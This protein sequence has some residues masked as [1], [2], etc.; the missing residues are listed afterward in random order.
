MNTY[1]C[2]EN[3]SFDDYCHRISTDIKLSA[4][5]TW[6]EVAKIINLNC[7]LDYSE[8]WYRKKEKNRALNNT[9]FGISLNSSLEDQALFLAKQKVKVSDERVQLNSIIRRLSREETIKDIAKE[10]ASIISKEKPLLFTTNPTVNLSSDRVGILLLSDWHY[11]IEI[12]NELNSYNPEIAKLRIDKLCLK[13]REYGY[14][15]GINTLYIANLGDMIAGNIHLPL[16]LNSRIDVITQILQVSELLCE[17]ICNLSYNFN[18]AYYS[19][20]DNHSRIEP[21]KNDSLDLESLSRITDWYIKERLPQ[22]MIDDNKLGKDICTTKILD[23]NIAFVHGHKD[24]QATLIKK[25]NTFTMQ[26][27]DLICSAHYHHFSADEECGTLMVAN[28]SIMGTDDYA[29]SQRLHA[30]PSQ[31][32]IISAPDNVCECIY[33]INVD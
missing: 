31:T 15:N 13:I 14:K 29:Y 20:L 16:R 3:E 26:H 22:V 7:N 4:G 18:I 19:V 11:G 25:L 10:A 9:A 12:S 1:P 24:T 6:E 32:L 2:N 28:G 21:N 8:S 17:F 33:K 27:F 23:H 30:K 5:L